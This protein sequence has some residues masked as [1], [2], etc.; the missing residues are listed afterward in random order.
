MQDVSTANSAPFA[1]K[2]YHIV[3]GENSFDVTSDSNGDILLDISPKGDNRH[4]SKT[5]I[6]DTPTTI[7]EYEVPADYQVL[8]SGTII[9]INVRITENKRDAYKK[10]DSTELNKA[11]TQ[12][13][14]LCTW[15]G[16]IL[17]A[18]SFL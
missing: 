5:V 15:V 17:F 8:P 12:P 11:P 7:T 13:Q 9:Y 6:V 10:A 1:G 2:T 14:N 4:L 16:V 3:N 18:K